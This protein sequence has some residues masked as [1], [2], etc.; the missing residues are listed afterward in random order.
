MPEQSD[1]LLRQN[2]SISGQRKATDVIYLGFCKVS[3]MLPHHIFI[4]K[5]GRYRFEE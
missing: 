1:G 3:D 2:D 4:A 5:W